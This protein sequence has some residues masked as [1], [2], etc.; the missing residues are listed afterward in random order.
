VLTA[1]AAATAAARRRLTPLGIFI[2]ILLTTTPQWR[3]QQYNWTASSARGE[4]LS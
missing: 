4:K 1:A 2:A 3:R